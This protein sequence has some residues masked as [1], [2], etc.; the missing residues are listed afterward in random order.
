M[1]PLDP[2]TAYC[3]YLTELG[4]VSVG[5]TDKY[6]VFIRSALRDGCV[7]ADNDLFRQHLEGYAQGGRSLRRTAWR[8]YQRFSGLSAGEVLPYRDR[9]S[10]DTTPPMLKQE[11]LRFADWLVETQGLAPA[12]ATASTS[13]IRTTLR[14]LSMEPSRADLIEYLARRPVSIRSRFAS[15]W[16]Y[17]RIFTNMSAVSLDTTD[18]V[19]K[20]VAYAVWYLAAQ[21]GMK[22]RH[23]RE[24]RWTDFTIAEDGTARI[25]YMPD[26]MP[27]RWYRQPV[28][29][30]VVNALNAWSQPW[31]DDSLVFPAERGGDAHV[32]R[33]QLNIVTTRGA[34]MARDGLPPDL[35]HIRA[36]EPPQE[37]RASRPPSRPPREAPVTRSPWGDGTEQE[38]KST[39]LA[40]VAPNS[41]R[42]WGS[43]LEEKD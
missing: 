29:A 31:G 38:S 22:L 39:P 27:G 35:T 37:R 24:L 15:A 1:P 13:V 4:T 12:T 32:G 41:A 5:M 20:E 11:M 16:N 17:W 42:D 43:K 7:P 2:L 25:V 36:A 10:I 9:G 30:G 6:A 14:A 33:K 34:D 23:I 40:D 8:H 21:V 3:A 18:D 19:P 28:P 26:P